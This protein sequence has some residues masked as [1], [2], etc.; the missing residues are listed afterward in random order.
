M[1]RLAA[2]LLL[3][4]ALIVAVTIRPGDPRLYPPKPGEP[5]VTVFL[6]DN[7]Y[8]S[9]IAMPGEALARTGG[10][11]AR[12]ARTLTPRSWVLAG[13]GDARFYMGQGWSVGRVL[14]GFRALFKPGNASV[15]Q[16]IGLAEPPDR[17][18]RTG[19]TRIVLSEAGFR[20]LVSRID[21]AFAGD[22]RTP[23]GAEAPRA[24]DQRFFKGAGTFNITHVCNEWAADA[25]N[26]AGLG[27]TPALDALPFGL[28]ADLELRAWL[29]H[30]PLDTAPARA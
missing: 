12:A 27:V 25:L 3:L 26:A 30:R 1:R 17:V 6:I 7:G 19:V 18:W 29:A 24:P 13:W 22:G 9:D 2:V 10:V 28:K 4:L 20:R 11:T 15:V 23:I 14:D 5:T 8:H 21:R 16:L